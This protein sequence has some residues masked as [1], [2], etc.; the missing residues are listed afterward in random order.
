[1][2]RHNKEDFIQ[3][4]DDYLDRYRNHCDG[5]LHQEGEIGVSSEYNRTKC[6]FIAKEQ[7]R[8]SVEGK[9]LRGNI[10]RKRGFWPN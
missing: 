9:L 8:G 4:G 10:R 2:L 1:M 6:K 3:A 7:G 5:I